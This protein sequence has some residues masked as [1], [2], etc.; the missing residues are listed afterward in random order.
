MNSCRKIPF[1]RRPAQNKTTHLQS[2]QYPTMPK[3]RSQARARDA[4][5]RPQ[6]IQPPDLFNKTEHRCQAAPELPVLGI[7]VAKRTFQACLLKAGQRAQERE[8]S[9]D[10]Q[11]F[12]ALERWLLQHDAPCTCAALEATGSY[13]LGLLVF[14]HEKDHRV[15]LL[16]P[17]WIKDYA[18]SEG[19]R[20]KTDVVDARIIGHYVLSHHTRE[21]QPASAQRQK[22]QALYRR[23]C[24][25]MEM[26]VAEQLRLQEAPQEVKASL[27]SALDHFDR[28]LQ[29]LDRELDKIIR[30]DAELN[31]QRQWLLSVPGIG[32]LTAAAILA[33]MPPL[34]CFERVRDAAAWAGLTPSL[35]TSGTSVRGRSR[36][37][38]QGNGRLRKALYM[39]ALAVLRS[40]RANAMTALARRLREAGKEEMIIVGAL[41]RKL[42]QVAC[43]VIRHRQG[44]FGARDAIARHAPRRAIRC[45][46]SAHGTAGTGRRWPWARA[47]EIPRQLQRAWRCR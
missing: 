4:A 32:K 8:F 19:R 44:A 33:E 47:G 28:Q 21:W 36:L 27:R 29:S 16:N 40:K 12:A 25:V 18:R 7:D 23:R 26:R 6:P 43:G 13:S 10:L 46:F 34:E 17:R 14:L 3:L 35:K 42:L 30:S 22:L 2:N 9:N 1:R 38:K 24:Q 41:M 37:S 45:S 31:Q 39:P 11:G 15:S 20:N 5:L